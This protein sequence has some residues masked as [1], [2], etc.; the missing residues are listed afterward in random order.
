MN[1]F[2][3]NR[4]FLLIAILFVLLSA[5][6]EAL[7]SNNNIK[8]HRIIPCFH[9]SFQTPFAFGFKFFDQ[10]FSLISSIPS[11]SKE[12]FNVWVRTEKDLSISTLAS[13]YSPRSNLFFLINFIVDEKIRTQSNTAYEHSI[14]LVFTQINRHYT[15]RDKYGSSL[16]RN[17]DVNMNKLA[18]MYRFAV[19]SRKH[20]VIRPTFFVSGGLAL[21]DFH[22]IYKDPYPSSYSKNEMLLK[23]RFDMGI[24]LPL[25]I[26]W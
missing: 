20:K 9:V 11:T 10:R 4:R 12:E 5:M 14:D 15:T 7:Y 19:S 3:L 23:P 1:H 24:T 16:N 21:V 2:T 8:T 26:E 18:M 13:N 17:F 25:R 22:L 6:P